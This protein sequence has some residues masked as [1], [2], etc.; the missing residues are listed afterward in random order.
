MVFKLGFKF[1]IDVDDTDTKRAN[2][3][4]FAGPH[5]FIWNG[6]NFPSFLKLV[7]NFASFSHKW[8]KIETWVWQP[9]IIIQQVY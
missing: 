1:K 7:Y 9:A 5:S 6:M 4:P 2:S 8:E 3:F